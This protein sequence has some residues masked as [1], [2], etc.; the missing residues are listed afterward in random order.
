[1]ILGRYNLLKRHQIF[2][3]NCLFFSYKENAVVYSEIYKD[4]FLKPID[5]AVYWIDYVLRNNGASY[6]KSNSIQLNSIQYLLV[7]I[8][9]SLSIGFVLLMYFFYKILKIVKCYYYT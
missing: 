7:D 2:K 3:I 1:M 8:I 4:G 6:L 5:R 9:I